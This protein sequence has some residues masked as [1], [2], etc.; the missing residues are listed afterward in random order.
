MKKNCRYADNCLRLALSWR[1]K[2]ILGLFAVLFISCNDDP[3]QDEP[4]TETPHVYY[5][6]MH[7]EVEQSHPGICPKPECQGMDLVLKITSAFDRVLKPV[8]SSVLASVKTINPVFKS[9]PM[10]LDLKGYI[11]YDDRTKNNISSLVSGRIEKLYVRYN[12][13]PVHKGQKIFEIYSPELVTAQENLVYLLNNDEEEQQLIRSAKQKLNLLGFTDEMM[14]TLEKEKKVSR[15]VP[16]YSKYEGH[17]HDQ[18]SS[19]QMADNAAGMQGVSVKEGQYIMMGETIF[20]IVSSEKLAVVLQ[21]VPGDI[22]KLSKNSEVSIKTEDGKILEGK[23]DFI[24]P[25]L[26]A[27]G[28]TL[29]A[30]VYFNNSSYHLKV[31]T[32]VTATVKSEGFEALWIP[33]SALMGLGKSNIVWV[34]KDSRFIAKKIEIGTRSGNMVEVA[35]GLTETD[36]I[37]AEAHYLI[38]SEGFVKEEQDEEK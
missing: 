19:M 31:G 23:I 8:N 16:V 13:Q 36:N 17:V 25:V 1:A 34:K 37:A 28:K 7:P 29:T 38:D 27:G 10:D 15:T 24:E 5:C 30:K 18:N 6:P 22:S 2:V 32:F 12:Y 33:A 9:M 11:D 21:V 14:N 4:V 20:N 35:D 3:K 26:K